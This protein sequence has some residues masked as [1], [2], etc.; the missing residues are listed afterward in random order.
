MK[1]KILFLGVIFCMFSTVSADVGVVVELPDGTL[2]T[3]CVK[4]ED[5]A[6]GYEV[7]GE[8]DLDITW[9][10]A[11]LWGHGLCDIEGVSGCTPDNCYCDPAQYWNFYIASGSSWQYSP[12]GFDAPGDCSAHYCAEHGGL[13]GFAFGGWGTKPDLVGFQDI[14]GPLEK[15]T[16]RHKVDTKVE[17]KDGK[18]KVNVENNGDFD[19]NIDCYFEDLPE[20]WNG[21]GIENGSVS[22]NGDSSF[23]SLVSYPRDTRPG[24]YT[25]R[26]ICEAGDS[27]DIEVLIIDVPEGCQ[28]DEDC[29]DTEFCHPEH[30]CKELD[31]QD[32]LDAKGH[33]CLKEEQKP[34]GEN[35]TAA[36]TDNESSG[37]GE[38][39]GNTT[40]D[41]VQPIVTANKTKENPDSNG[42]E[43]PLQTPTAPEASL[44]NWGSGS[45]GEELPLQTPTGQATS[46]TG[47]FEG[48]WDWFSSLF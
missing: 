33:K 39:P 8:T 34:V 3:E 45:N 26:F 7:L 36:E 30:Y 43:L 25:L 11:G 38:E 2:F 4:I 47:F 16:E 20:G 24:R 21:T 28:E 46:G 22:M 44:T 12:T 23:D 29:H 1:G 18:L 6:N 19:E 9:S 41:D 31:C 10:A 42:E 37:G 5:G 14:C 27:K 48:L 40:A 17:F 15:P 13:M 35:K 32:G